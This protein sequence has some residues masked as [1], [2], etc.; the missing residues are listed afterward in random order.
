MTRRHTALLFGASLVVFLAATLPLSLALPMLNLVARGLTYDRA[1]GTIWRGEVQG[2]RWRGHDLGNAHISVRAVALLA[3]RLSLNVGLD[4]R[5]A[6]QGAGLVSI[7][8][9]GT[10]RLADVAVTA[11][12][13]RLPVIL[14]VTG[15][16]ALTIDDAV[17]TN[18]GCEHIAGSVGTDALV[19]RPAGVTWSG[20]VLNGALACRDGALQVPLKGE[21]ADGTIDLAMRVARDG[22]FGIDIRARTSNQS[23]TGLLSTVG[24]V[25]AGGTMILTQKGRWLAAARR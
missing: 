7:A 13:A 9:T 16:I 8:P 3:G 14:P 6:V 17:I 1:D 5:G 19:H 11:D 4:G 21:S 18:T 23:I 12:V 25:D 22:T 24:F 10:I 20:P 15:K 2:L